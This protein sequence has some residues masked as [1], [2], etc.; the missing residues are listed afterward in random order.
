MIV[1]SSSLLEQMAFQITI[2][3]STRFTVGSSSRVRLKVSGARKIIACTEMV[4]TSQREANDGR[5]NLGRQAYPGHD[6]CRDLHIKRR[7]N[8]P[9]WHEVGHLEKHPKRGPTLTIIE[10]RRPLGSLEDGAINPFG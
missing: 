1:R 2:E 5:C 4:E 3:S 10:K 9:P 7:H 6:G 8:T